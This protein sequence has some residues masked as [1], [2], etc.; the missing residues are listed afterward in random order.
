MSISI[1]MHFLNKKSAMD[2]EYLKEGTKDI[3][4]ENIKP[5]VFQIPNYDIKTGKFV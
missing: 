5:P 1:G 3:F 4:Y 2:K